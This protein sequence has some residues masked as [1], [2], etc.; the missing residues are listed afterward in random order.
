MS[1]DPFPQGCYNYFISAMGQQLDQQLGWGSTDLGN[2]DL[3]LED[4]YRRSTQ[5]HGNAHPLSLPS[6]LHEEN[7]EHLS[8]Q[9]LFAEGLATTVLLT[10]SIL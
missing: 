3:G 6:T 2:I 5:Q 10:K 9:W 7:G 8:G 1:S 4:M